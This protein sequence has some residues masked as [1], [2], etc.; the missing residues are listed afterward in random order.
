[1]YITSKVYKL[2]NQV[3][4]K[5]VTISA[6]KHIIIHKSFRYNFYEYMYV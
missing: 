4:R 1:V 6:Q 3:G 2:Q 5:K